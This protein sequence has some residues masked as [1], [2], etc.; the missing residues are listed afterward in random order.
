MINEDKLRLL[1]K[2][3]VLEK[4]SHE[5]FNINRY[6]KKDYVAYH[7]LLIW[8]CITVAYIAVV[9]GV[10][11]YL[12]EEFPEMVQEMNFGIVLFTLLMVYIIVVIVYSIIS[13]FV[14]NMRY[15]KAMT[16]VKKYNG[17]L[18][19][20]EKEYEKEESSRKAE[21]EKKASEDTLVK[22]RAYPSKMAYGHGQAYVPRQA[23]DNKKNAVRRK[24]DKA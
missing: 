14:Y 16:V 2:T 8:I 24:G 1:T 10:A 7:V 20:I 23:R 17:S 11:A 6:Y 19:L 9:C 22:G 12:I 21:R 18:K 4:N 5:Q 3:A 15:D 13:M